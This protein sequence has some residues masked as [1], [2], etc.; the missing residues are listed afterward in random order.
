MIIKA[1]NATPDIGYK[2]LFLAGSIE[3]GKA[4][5]W[6][7]RLAEDIGHSNKP[8]I[9]NDPRR[10]DWDSSWVQNID[11][12][13]FHAQVSWELEHI[14]RAD[15]V[16]FYFDAN[17]QSPITLM[18]LGLVAGLYKPA[19]V[20]CPEPFWRKGN[21]DILCER[22]NIPMVNSYEDLVAYVNATFWRKNNV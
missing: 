18:E 19:V 7:K 21:V 2:R 10:D 9:V 3:M 11:N 4:E 6:Q 13:M 17:T 20:Y 5:H 12:K 16:V 22:Y 8:L 14:E 1:P 15:L